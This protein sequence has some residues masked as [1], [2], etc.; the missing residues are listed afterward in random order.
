[1]SSIPDFMRL[2]MTFQQARELT[3]NDM[4]TAR[5]LNKAFPVINWKAS[6]FESQIIGKLAKRASA[7]ADKSGFEYTPM[8]A[9]LDITA[10]HLNCCALNLNKLAQAEDFDF[11][12]DVFGIRRHINRDTAQ[13]EDCFVPRCALSNHPV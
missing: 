2:G 6:K 5:E 3:D 4:R 11:A 10:C 7:M 9:R 1:M 12:H 13:L 8:D